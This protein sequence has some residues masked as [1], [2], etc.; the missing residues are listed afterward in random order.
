MGAESLQ[1]SPPGS[2]PFPQHNLLLSKQHPPGEAGLCSG[3]LGLLPTGRETQDVADR[4]ARLCEGG[5]RG[6]TALCVIPC[7][8]PCY[9]I[10]LAQ[11]LTSLG[12][13]SHLQ[14]SGALRTR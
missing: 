4:T 5:L 3:P 1:S 10:T 8:T 2:W 11:V 13:S 14:S 7:S 6:P 9:W 12:L